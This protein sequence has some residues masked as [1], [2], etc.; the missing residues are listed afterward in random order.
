MDILLM[1]RHISK[2]LKKL[3]IVE[4]N[5]KLSNGKLLVADPSI[6]GDF[7]FTRAV[8]LLADHNDEGSVGFIL[9]KPMSHDLRTFVPEISQPFSVF[10]GGPVD[11]DR[12][13]YIHSRRD[14]IPN[15]KPISKE[16]AW[17]GDFDIITSMINNGELSSED[18][19]FFLGY[20]GWS[21]DQLKDEVKQKTWIVLDDG[22]KKVN[23]STSNDASFWKSK[24][25]RLGGRYILWA[26]SPSNPQLN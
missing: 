5:A 25:M 4:V 17:G 22:D 26:N 8:I 23:I 21:C 24:M 7:S 3:Y 19:K 20:S 6:I 11:Q 18:I 15:S 13:Y 9:N 14:C 16:L 10:E 2:T 1:Q 12:L